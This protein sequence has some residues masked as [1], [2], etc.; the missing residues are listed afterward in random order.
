MRKHYLLLAHDQPAHVARL[1]RRLHDGESTF[2]LHLDAR[3]DT[4]PWRAVLDLPDVVAVD[5]RVRCLWGT[6][7]MVEAQLV[8]LR[9][10][11]AAAVPG[12][13]VMLSG[14]SYPVKSTAHI[15]AYLTARQDRVHMDLWALHERWPDNFRDRLDYFCVPM[16]ERKGDLRLLRRRQDMNAR[17]LVGWTRRLLREVGPRRAAE[18]LAVIGR[19]RPAVGDRV[20]GGSQW[21]ALPWDVASKVPELGERHPEYAEF[22]RWS[23]YPDESYVQT[24]LVAT[25]DSV[26]RRVAPTLTF[27]D[28]TEGDWDL[29][30]V[31]GP[32]DVPRLLAQP[33]HVLF[34]R[35]FLSP[36]SD[37]VADALDRAVGGVH[38]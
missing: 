20:V 34:A 15:D 16:S 24:L 3:V 21:W 35:K 2:W 38:R 33:E 8:L 9:A 23:Q 4:G 19:P 28:W 25:D 13:V 5:T 27:V 18:V 29:P 7:S 37:E 30:R 11:L 31:M 14:Q 36:T 17:E 32:D 22:L 26:R 6:W 10:C 12:Y 1:L